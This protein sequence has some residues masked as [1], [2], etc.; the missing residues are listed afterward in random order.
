M[1][2]AEV[3]EGKLTEK[4]I[5]E[6]MSKKR[7]DRF[8]VGADV[9]I[10]NQKT[11]KKMMK[12]LGGHRRAQNFIYNER[13]YE[14]FCLFG[15]TKRNVKK[16]E[17]NLRK[18]N[19]KKEITNINNDVV[20]VKE[21]RKILDRS[22]IIDNELVKIIND[23]NTNFYQ[24]GKEWQ[25]KEKYFLFITYDFNGGGSLKENTLKIKPLLFFHKNVTNIFNQTSLQGSKSLFIEV[26]LNAK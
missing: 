22:N 9:W 10:V 16:Y 24:E 1:K 19:M 4:E 11:T 14:F 20:T 13:K 12:D 3:I 18:R 7:K 17:F 8:V 21:Q 25:S 15:F 5:Q 23:S 2:I 6:M 26:S